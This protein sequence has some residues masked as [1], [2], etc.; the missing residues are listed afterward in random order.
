MVLLVAEDS[1]VEGLLFKLLLSLLEGDRSLRD[2]HTFPLWKV[3]GKENPEE[4]RGLLGVGWNSVAGAH[5]SHQQL[6][7]IGR[8]SCVVGWNPAR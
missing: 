2:G 6:G 1:E 3:G 8:A 5:L 4:A 7:Q